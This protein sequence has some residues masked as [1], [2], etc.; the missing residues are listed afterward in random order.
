MTDQDR[1]NLRALFERFSP[2]ED[3]RA[4]ADEIRRAQEMLDAYPAPNPRPQTLTRIRAEMAAK[5]AR[6]HRISRIYRFVSAAAAVVV[7][8][9][10]G[11]FAHAP[12]SDSGISHASLLPAAIWDSDD[13]A[14][15]DM[16]LAYFTAEISRIEAEIQA[17]QSDERDSPGN[18]TLTELEIQL[19]LLRTRFWKE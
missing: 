2:A 9:L 10:I 3:A 1:D 13:I 5:L 19:D 8:G 15:D 6:K 11:L 12:R 14:S 16:D 4:A 7:V 18:D 17:I